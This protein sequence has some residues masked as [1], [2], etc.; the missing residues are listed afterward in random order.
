MKHKAKRDFNS[1]ALKKSFK[2][3]DILD[4]DEKHLKE[5]V[6]NGLAVKE[7]KPASARKTKE[8]K[9]TSKTK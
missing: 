3:G 4:A 2:K 8:L 7:S 5:W 6:A 1:I 9:T